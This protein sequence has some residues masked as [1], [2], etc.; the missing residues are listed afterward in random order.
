M[1]CIEQSFI[2][3]ADLIFQSYVDS[4]VWGEGKGNEMSFSFAN[5]HRGDINKHVSTHQHGERNEGP[6]HPSDM[7]L[8]IL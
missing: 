8:I 4:D 5:K 3:V 7:H 2:V 1:D 6:R